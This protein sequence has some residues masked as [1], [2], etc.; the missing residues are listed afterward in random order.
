MEVH[1]FMNSM[2]PPGSV[3]MSQMAT[4]LEGRLGQPWD[5]FSH[6]VETSVSGILRRGV[7]EG[8]VDSVDYDR[9]VG[10]TLLDQF[11]RY[12]SG[13]LFHSSSP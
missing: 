12:H 3:E 9:G 2:K 10:N 5:F 7:L 6:G 1:L 8:P 4:S 11:L 13:W